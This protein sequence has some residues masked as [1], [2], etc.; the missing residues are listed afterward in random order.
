MQ[1]VRAQTAR[2]IRGNN[3]QYA[4]TVVLSFLSCKVPETI[5]IQAPNAQQGSV[6]DQMVYPYLSHI[7]DRFFAGDAISRRVFPNAENNHKDGR[8][9]PVQ[10]RPYS[11]IGYIGTKADK[12]GTVSDT[13]T[14]FM[15][16]L[17]LKKNN[18][19]DKP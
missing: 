1:A 12:Y 8:L 2:I 17:E 16:A 11:R 7:E 6:P 4:A 13:I 14:L 3:R 10:K 15:P 18:T 19:Q 9:H 5:K